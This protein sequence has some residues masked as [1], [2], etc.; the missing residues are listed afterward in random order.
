MKKVKL[1]GLYS[2]ALTRFLLDRDYEIVSPSEKIRERFKLKDEEKRIADVQIYDSDD[3]DGIIVHGEECDDL[4]EELKKEFMDIVIRKK[5][6][7]SIYA[8]EVKKISKG[9]AYIDLGE[10]GE[11][12]LSTKKVDYIKLGSKILVQ[13]KGKTRNKKILSSQLRLFGESI[14]LIHE[15]FDKVSKYIKDPDERQR[16]QDIGK[17]LD[18]KDWG[19]LWKTPAKRKEEEELEKEAKQLLSEESEIRREFEKKKKGLIKKGLSM[20][21]I[22]FGLLSKVKLDTIRQK[23]VPTLQSHHLFKSSGFQQLIDLGEQF[24]NQLSEKDVQKRISEVMKNLG[25]K[26]GHYYYVR[27]KKPSGRIINMKGKVEEVKE[28][29]ITV[30]REMRGG[31]EYDGLQIPKKEGDY[32][33]TTIIPGKWWIKHEYYD[34]QN[35]LKGKYYSINTPIEVFPKK[36]K[37]VDLEIDVVQVKG[38]EKKVVDEEDLEKIYDKQ[39]IPKALYEKAREIVEVIKNEKH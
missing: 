1:R 23:V 2:T 36:A 19:V 7:G 12:L 27:H 31:G 35:N 14:I 26:Q 29:S 11:G 9:E 28:E 16:L 21:T 8:G 4:V 39:Q 6:I 34:N 3:G 20:Y 33:L 17:K 38:E 22:D 32:A 37:Y 5:E 10:G 18:L 25:P 24:L 13:V 30:R 15:G